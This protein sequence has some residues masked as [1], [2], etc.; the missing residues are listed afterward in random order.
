MDPSLTP[1][2]RVYVGFHD[3]RLISGL[4]SFWRAQLPLLPLSGPFVI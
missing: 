4:R 1:K 3:D 2:R